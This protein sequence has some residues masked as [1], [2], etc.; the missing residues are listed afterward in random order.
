M[1]ELK[2]IDPRVSLVFADWAYSRQIYCMAASNTK[3]LF[4]KIAICLGVLSSTKLVEKCSSKSR[5][6]TKPKLES[7]YSKLTVCGSYF[8]FYW[9]SLS[10][11]A[12]SQG[13]SLF[14]CLDS[15]PASVSLLE[16]SNTCSMSC[17]NSFL[18]FL[19]TSSSFFRLTSKLVDLSCLSF[20]S[21]SSL[22]R[23]C[24]SLDW[25][26]RS[27]PY[28]RLVIYSRFIGAFWEA[29]SGLELEVWFNIFFTL[30]DELFL[31]WFAL[32][33]VWF[34]LSFFALLISAVFGSG[35][36]ER[37]GF[38]LTRGLAKGILGFTIFAADF[39]WANLGFWSG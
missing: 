39:A 32:M 24:Y 13:S 22:I 5:K 37:V 31:T 30:F 18:N 21:C 16:H 6:V 2:R 12:R 34:K 26:I 1:N 14:V 36:R 7:M 15:S 9:V 33:D 3:K 28:R 10:I 27:W 4:L 35:L 38:D 8:S 17:L 23:A 25:W 11:N 29:D 19:S 20:S